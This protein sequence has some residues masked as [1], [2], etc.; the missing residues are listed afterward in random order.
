MHAII[1]IIVIGSYKESF[2]KEAEQEFL[3]RLGPFAKIT[4]TEIPEES[5]GKNDPKDRT[6]AKEAQIL[7]KHLLDGAFVIALDE[8]GKE[9]SSK[10]FAAFLERHAAGGAHL[11]FVIGGA[12]GLHSSVKES[13]DAVVSLSSLTFPHQMARVVLLEQLY[14]AMTILHGKTYHY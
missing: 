1:H 6:A 7:K 14:R 2:W 8:T 4:V 12:R 5:F 9:F 3:K 13:A 11:A 10:T